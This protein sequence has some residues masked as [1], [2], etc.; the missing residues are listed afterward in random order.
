[1]FLIEEKSTA[2][3]EIKDTETNKMVDDLHLT[4]QSLNYSKNE[5]K[6]I[7]PIIMKETDDLTK[8]DKNT[9]FENLLKLAMDFLDKNG[10]NIAR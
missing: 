7:L 6:S 9:S 5:I 2:E 1:M 10:S 4:L 8:K 3:F